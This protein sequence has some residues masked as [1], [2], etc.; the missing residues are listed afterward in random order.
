MQRSATY[1]IV[2][3]ALVCVVCSVVVSAAAVLLKDRQDAN[4]VAYRQENVLLAAG[5]LEPGESIDAEEVARRFETIQSKVIDLATGE[6]APEVDVAT[7]DQRTAAVDAAT[8]SLAPDNR[9]QVRRVPDNALVYELRDEAG[10]LEM[11]ILPIEGKGLWSTLYGFLALR[12]DLRTIGGITFYEHKETP[13][14]GGEVDNSRWKSL[15]PGRL[16]FDDNQDVAITVVKG[17]AGPPGEDPYRV[18][19]LSGATLTSRGVTNLL[20]FWL[21][22][23]GFGP[24]LDRLREAS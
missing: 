10:Q 14:L 12:N 2:F 15:W 3:A 20:Q 19:G 8:S 16:A 5:R 6:D 24:Y 7:F 21:G 23:D 13:G 11:V 9:A 18:D 1:I 22:E 4:A 17:P